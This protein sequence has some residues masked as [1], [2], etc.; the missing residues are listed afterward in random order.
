VESSTSHPTK[1]S[2]ASPVDS[3]PLSTPI[4]VEDPQTVD[5]AHT[6]DYMSMAK[7]TNSPSDMH[8]ATPVDAG[9]SSDDSDSAFDCP[10]CDK[11]YTTVKSQKVS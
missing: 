8:G 3:S 9:L 4:S 1:K 6:L 2:S 7:H 11:T 10:Y 5:A